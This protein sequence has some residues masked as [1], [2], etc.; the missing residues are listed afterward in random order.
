MI[1]NKK[2]KNNNNV[3]RNAGSFSQTTQLKAA[4]AI[5]SRRIHKFFNKVDL[6]DD[7]SCLYDIISAF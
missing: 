2:K 7:G 3:R 6:R 4:A 1:F 5:R